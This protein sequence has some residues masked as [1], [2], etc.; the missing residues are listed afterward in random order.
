MALVRF[1]Q[2]SD[3]WRGVDESLLTCWDEYAFLGA[4][5]M[6][7]LR[8][9][10]PAVFAGGCAPPRSFISPLHIIPSPPRV[11]QNKH[12][13]LEQTCS[14][15]E[16]TAWHQNTLRGK[17]SPPQ[18]NASHMEILKLPLKDPKAIWLGGCTD[19]S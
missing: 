14:L 15:N 13:P 18:S 7:T 12:V 16:N 1:G 17:F 9:D 10:Q 6:P 2:L 4:H 19:G 5:L 11:P 3:A 8:Q